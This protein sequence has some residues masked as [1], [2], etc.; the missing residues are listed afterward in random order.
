MKLKQKDWILIAAFIRILASFTR[1]GWHYPDE[2]Y[3]TIEFTRLLLGKPAIYTHETALHLRNLSWPVALMLPEWIAQVLSPHWTQFRLICAQLLAGMLDLCAIWAFARLSRDWTA[4]WRTLGFALLIFPW[5]RVQDSVS[6]GAEHIADCLIWLALA[7]LAVQGAH[8]RWALLMAGLISTAIFAV[9]YPAGLVSLGL[10]IGVLAQAI[11]E[12]QAKPF[13]Y[14]VA[15]L[16]LGLGI[17]GAADWHYYGRPWESL[18]MYLQYNVL[19]DAGVTAFG[20]QSAMQ[21]FDFFRSRWLHV[22]L[23]FGVAFAVVGAAALG[24]GIRRFEPWALAFLAYF[25]GHLLISHREERFMFP[26]EVLLLWGSLKYLAETRPDWRAPRWLVVLFAISALINVPLFLKALFGETGTLN[27]T[28]FEVDQHLIENPNTCAVISQH[29]LSSLLIP[30]DPNPSQVFGVF[31][32]ERRKPT[33]PQ[34]ETASLGWYGNSPQCSPEQTVL[35]HV[36]RPDVAWVESGCKLQR[37]GLLELLPQSLW[38]PFLRR[39]WVSGPW[40]ACSA[41]ILERFKKQFAESPFLH[42]FAHFSELPPLGMSAKELAEFR[43]HYAPRVVCK[44]TCP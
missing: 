25:L 33:F 29:L 5:F 1:V 12:K 22:L 42:E 28:Y 20:H 41:A 14:Y 32:A 2:W 4:R 8:R 23:P 15:G 3:Q 44:E 10:S 26:A 7:S 31:H 21:Y 43:D 35:L 40:Y 39:G 24:R 27:A 18:W 6:I 11:R 16:I 36:D 17:F 30:G 34:A 9:K 37:S 19:T 38:V 13:L